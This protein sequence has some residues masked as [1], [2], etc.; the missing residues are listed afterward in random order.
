MP[1]PVVHFEIG[2]RDREA[3][4]KFYAELFGWSI[5]HEEPASMI[6]AADRGIPGHIISLGH[7]PEHYVTF[8]VEVDDLAAALA[9]AESLGGRTLVPPVPVPPRGTFA[10]FEDPDGN[11]IGLWKPA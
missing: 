4:E 6:A 9:K 3:A 7:A 2:C 5:L 8:Y 11:T 10:W 1:N